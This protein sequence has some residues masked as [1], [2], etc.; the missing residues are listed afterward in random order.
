[1]EYMNKTKKIIMGFMFSPWSLLLLC[2]IYYLSA[3]ISDVAD[4]DL[5]GYLAFGRLF[6]NNAT[7]PYQDLF[8]YIPVKVPWIYHEW[9]TGVVFYPIYDNLGDIGL[10]GLRYLFTLLTLGV[11][12]WSAKIRGS[13]NG[14]VFLCMFLSV[15]VFIFGYSPVRAQIS[16]YLFFAF[17]LYLLE[18]SRITGKWGRLG[19]LIPM[20]ILWCNL[21][22]G[23]VAGLGLILLYVVGE[24]LSR[25]QYFT[26]IAILIPSALVT[27]INPYG[28]DYWIYTFDAVTMPRPEITEWLNAYAGIEQ[29]S[30]TG[31]VLSFFTLVFFSALLYAIFHKRDITAGLVLAVT[32]YLGFSHVRHIVFFALAF[33]VFMPLTFTMFWGQLRE[34]LSELGRMKLASALI[35]LFFIV[36]IIDSFCT[37]YNKFVLGSPFSLQTTSQGRNG[38]TKHHYPVGATEYIQSNGLKGNILPH[39]DWG[40]YLIWKLYPDCKVG[41]D[42]RYETVYPDMV[43]KAY[44]NFIYGREGWKEFLN[45]YPHDMIL[46]IAGSKIHG[47]LREEKNW[48][49]AYRG[50]GT[51]LFLNRALMSR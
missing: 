26:Y 35:G 2:I 12:G 17:S 33:M 22:G 45:R 40:E 6:W 37:F 5:W 31:A 11:A 24:A 1:M 42:G 29:E 43:H 44:F 23:F 48:V 34:K 14:S 7:F 46:V 39:F 25:R 47:L 27:L 20:Q 4:P 9:L 28:F 15:Y 50:Q 13:S 49:E 36:I 3:I 41:M 16:T 30:Y 21:H 38:K 19:W 32:A 10:Q 51:S 18:S 8:S